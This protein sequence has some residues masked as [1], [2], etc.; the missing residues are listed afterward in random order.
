MFNVS[1]FPDWAHILRLLVAFLLTS[2]FGIHAFYNHKREVVDVASPR[3]WMYWLYSL[4][5][6]G[7]SIA[8]FTQLCVTIV[9]RDYEKASFHLGYFTLLLI[10]SYAALIAGARHRNFD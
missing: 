2:A 4:V 3:R 9:F 1:Q 10:L 7:V 8:N 5:F 6:L